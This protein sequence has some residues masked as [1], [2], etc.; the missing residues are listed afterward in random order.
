MELKF[1]KSTHSGNVTIVPADQAGDFTGHGHGGAIVELVANTTD[2]A[3][4]K[5]VPVVTVEG[6]AVHVQ[7]GEV[8]HPMTPE[9]LIGL[10]V[11]VTEKGYQVVKLTSDDAPEADFAVAAG[12]KPLAVYEYCNLH[13][14]W[15]AEL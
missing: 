7:V 9:H 8:A 4:E 2:A 10:I 14:L 5:H 12:D 6:N 3:T 13:G 1:F 15:V 11:L